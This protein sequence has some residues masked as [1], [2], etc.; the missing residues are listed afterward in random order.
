MH[1]FYF[2]CQDKGLHDG[3]HVEEGDADDSYSGAVRE[4]STAF[5]RPSLSS[6]SKSLSYPEMS[7][8]AISVSGTTSSHSNESESSRIL[9]SSGM[10]MKIRPSLEGRVAGMSLPMQS[11]NSVRVSVLRSGSIGSLED[12]SNNPG[13]N[14]PGAS[15]QQ[16]FAGKIGGF[17]LHNNNSTVEGK[18]VRAS[19]NPNFNASEVQLHIN[20]PWEMFRDKTVQS[21]KEVEFSFDLNRDN[22]TVGIVIVAGMVCMF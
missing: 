3:R 13:D 19:S 18:H 1:E 10:V 14:E 8:V 6:I 15:S 9:S 21:D 17:I 11:P 4:S 7:K 5:D 20:I 2:V 12:L 16:P 22:F